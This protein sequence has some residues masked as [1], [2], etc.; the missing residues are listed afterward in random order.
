[1]MIRVYE[2]DIKIFL[3]VML[4]LGADAML[5]LRFYVAI[6]REPRPIEF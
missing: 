6:G 3:N 2:I 4:L 5:C 1:M